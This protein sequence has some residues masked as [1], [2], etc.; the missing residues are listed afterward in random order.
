MAEML[1]NGTG[2]MFPQDTGATS[3][4]SPPSHD[5]TARKC[6]KRRRTENDQ[7]DTDDVLNRLKKLHKSIMEDE[8]RT[9]GALDDEPQENITSYPK[10]T[11]TETTAVAMKA[12]GHFARLQQ[13][14]DNKNKTENR[15]YLNST[16]TQP[17]EFRY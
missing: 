13:A 11:T 14:L 6:N 10:Q 8:E 3:I 9:I 16:S 5:E 15:N 12:G 17:M 7:P 1:S 4:R 2:D